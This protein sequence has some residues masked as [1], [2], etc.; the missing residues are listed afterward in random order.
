MRNGRWLHRTLLAVLLPLAALPHLACGGSGGGSPTEPPPAGLSLTLTATPSSIAPQGTAQVVVQARDPSGGSVA[1]LP[2]V[3]ATS[4]GSL[5]LTALTTDAT[6][7]ATTTLRGNAVAGTA[8]LTAQVQGRGITAAAEVRIGLDAALEVSVEP[9]SIFGSGEAAVTVRVF[10]AGGGPA[11]PGTPVTLSTT[12]GELASTAIAVDALGVARTTLRTGGEIG[13]A[14][15]TAS[16]LGVSAAGQVVLRPPYQLRVTLSPASIPSTGRAGVTVRLVALDPT[17]PVGNRLVRLETTRGRLADASV[18]T[19]ALGVATTSLSA[20]GETGN[21]M[22]TATMAGAESGTA[23]F[24]FGS[25]GL[26]VSVTASP[27]S[28][29]ANGGSSTI[30]VLVANAQG[31]PVVGAG[32]DLATTRG[33][34]DATRVRTGAGGLVTAVLR[35]DG[36]TGQAVVSATIQGTSTTDQVVVT[37]N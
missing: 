9:H 35:G 31:S 37:F 2:I 14:V 29:P 36:T 32:V 30:T 27:A 17:A 28:V 7:R 4:L 22:V 12:R 3:L 15:V 8:R 20:A 6:G 13:T 5:D 16:A 33:L 34:L 21:G 19:N 25:S 24:F 23:T 1:G 10:Q 18:R 11:P 26:T